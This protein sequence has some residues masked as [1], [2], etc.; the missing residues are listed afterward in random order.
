[1]SA[2][3][4]TIREGFPYPSIDKQPG[5]P[6]YAIISEVHKK[7]KT[8]SASV[9]SNLGGGQHSFL[10]L[11]L[12]AMTYTTLTG[13]PFILHTNPGTV[14]TIPAGSSSPQISQ[15]ERAHNEELREW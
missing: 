10:G 12:Q 2:T 7:L 8:N 14:L 4:E 9:H 1:M 11:T 5:Y 3:V 6:T 15:F 13:V